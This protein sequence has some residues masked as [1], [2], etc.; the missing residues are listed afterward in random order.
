MDKKIC[1]R[2]HAEKRLFERYD[3]CLNEERYEQLINKKNTCSIIL[4]KFSDRRSLLAMR[5]KKKTMFFVFDEITDE[6]V[7]FLPRNKKLMY[8]YKKKRLSRFQKIR[9]NDRI[10]NRRYEHSVLLG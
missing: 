9:N 6:F 7:T 1:E 2:I 5:Y 4:E 8:L 3:L 10:E